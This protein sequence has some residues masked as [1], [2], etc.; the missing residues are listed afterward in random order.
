MLVEEGLVEN[1][2][3]LGA[4]ALE[5]L[6]AIRSPHVREVR[7]RGLWIGIELKAAAGGARRFCEPLAAEGMLCKETHTPRHP[8]RAAARH[9]ATRA[10]LGAGPL[11]KGVDASMRLSKA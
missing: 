4:Y 3:E 6:R 7:G 1:A 8:R 2:A 9:H 11:R 5:R 10:R